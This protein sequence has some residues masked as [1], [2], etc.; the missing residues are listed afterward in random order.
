MMHHDFFT[1]VE[2]LYVA[3]A[4]RVLAIFDRL[5]ATFIRLHPRKE[6]RPRL[7]WVHPV[8]ILVAQLHPIVFFQDRGVVADAF[9][10]HGRDPL[11][12]LAPLHDL[13]P[14]FLG[15]V[16]RVENCDRNAGLLTQPSDGL[17]HARRRDPLADRRVLRVVREEVGAR[18]RPALLPPHLAR[19]EVPYLD[20]R[21][22]QIAHQHLRDVGL[23]ARRQ[24]HHANEYPARLAVPAET[25]DA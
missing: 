25:V 23:A 24:A 7:P 22:L 17:F 21:P 5:V 19:V 14:P 6:V 3:D 4:P 18:A 20:A 11:S 15:G 13:G 16:S 1:N 9:D 2:E 10:E 8:V 12:L